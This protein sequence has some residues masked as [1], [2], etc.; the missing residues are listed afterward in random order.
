MLGKSGLYLLNSKPGSLLSLLAIY[1]HQ[2]QFYLRNSVNKFL[3]VLVI[4]NFQKVTGFEVGPVS[5]TEVQPCQQRYLGQVLKALVL[6]K[7]RLRG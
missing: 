6:E 1:L 2:C 3:F 5:L 4:F 7:I